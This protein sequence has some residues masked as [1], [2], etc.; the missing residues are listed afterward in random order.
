MM[1][2]PRTEKRLASP[3]GNAQDRGFPKR[4]IYVLTSLHEITR[5][6]DQRPETLGEITFDHSCVYA[7][8]YHDT[9]SLCT[10]LDTRERQ[11][12]VCGPAC[13]RHPRVLYLKHTGPLVPAKNTIFSQNIQ[14]LAV[15]P[16][17]KTALESRF[18]CRL[19][20]KTMCRQWPTP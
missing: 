15:H 1:Q 13:R 3:R 4:S 12:S 8:L 18:Q 7:S 11:V 16:A 9:R 10:R 17:P 2:V 19:S 20:R 14:W 6:G 5:A